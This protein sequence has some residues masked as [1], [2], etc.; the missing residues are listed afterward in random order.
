[1]TKYREILRPVYPLDHTFSVGG[2][3]GEDRLWVD[4]SDSIMRRSTH[5]PGLTP[6]S[7]H[8]FILRTDIS[9]LMIVWYFEYDWFSFYFF[10]L[11]CRNVC[12]GI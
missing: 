4:V 7:T 6:L 3:H 9:I 5:A 10:V 11:I 1:M 2:S 8:C 12:N